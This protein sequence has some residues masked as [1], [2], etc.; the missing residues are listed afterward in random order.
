TVAGES[1]IG[2]VCRGPIACEH[3][4][5]CPS[6]RICVAGICQI[7][8]P[9]ECNPACLPEE[10]CAN[11]SCQIP[12]PADC[13]QTP[14]LLPGTVCLNGMCRI[15]NDADDDRDMDCDGL[16]DWNERLRG[17]NPLNSDTDGDGLLD[18]VE[19]GYGSL[20]D[21]LC[22][23]RYA[24]LPPSP[25]NKT[26]PLRIDTDCDGLTDGEEDANGNGVF[27]LGETNPNDPDTDNDGILD[28][29]ELGRQFSPDS[30]CAGS[31]PQLPE[32]PN[33][34]TDPL[35][36]DSD[37]DGMLDGVEDTNQNGRV[38]PGETNPNVFDIVDPVVE[39]ACS[40]TNLVPVDIRRNLAAQ[41]ALGLPMGFA[42]NY[43]DIQRGN[44]SGLMGVDLPRNV[45]FVAWRHVSWQNIGAVS[46]LNMLRNLARAQA[47]SLVGADSATI[48]TFDSWD[49][50]PPPPEHNALSVSFEIS[51]NMSP[52]ARVNDIA[53]R[54][55]GGGTGS[56]T[57]GANVGNRQYV[58]AQ[59]VLR[60]DGEVVVVMAVALDN[61][62]V[63]GT[64]A[65][66]GLNDVAGGAA[67]ARYF[68]RTVVQC[69][70]G[71]VVRREVDILFVVDDSS[72]MSDLQGRLGMAGNTMA[73]ALNNSNLD[74]RV[75]LVS[76]DYHTTVSAATDG[77]NNN[78]RVIRGF[79]RDVG[80]FQAWLTQNNYC[81]RSDSTSIACSDSNLVT[82]GCSCVLSRDVACLP[83]ATGVGHSGGCWLG[84]SGSA[85]EGMLG[86]ARLALI[87]M[88]APNADPRIQLRANSEVIV[89][90][91]SDT[92]DQTRTL[93]H[94]SGASSYWENIQNFVRFFRGEDTTVNTTTTGNGAPIVVSPVRPNITIQVNAIYCPAGAN[95]GGGN[96]VAAGTT[97]RIQRVVEETGGYLASI[98]S[99]AAI[100]NTMRDIV[101]GAI[102]RGG[103]VTQKPFLGA[104]L[105]VA[106]Q[107]PER[108]V[109]AGGACNGSNVQRSR[110]HGFDYDGI[111]QAVTFFGDCRPENHT[112]VA[113]SYRAWESTDRT[114]LPCQYDIHFDAN[115][116]D[117]CRGLRSCELS[118]DV[119]VCPADCG[120]CGQ[121]SHCVSDRRRCECVPN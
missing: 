69:E 42:N 74:W 44:T 67:L 101:E 93:Y 118:T 105:R 84:N 8:T 16:E 72:S 52:A 53:T 4:N 75:A 94:S 99:E 96:I 115:A 41:L 19:V 109:S 66:F 3:D 33:N 63:A 81:R 39:A 80:E 22:A 83:D 62:N 15:P 11:G 60:A 65:F 12:G 71:E 64:P 90:I 34:P 21:P 102:G 32:P 25:T 87:N 27:D 6:G 68:D 113:I 106:I 110:E 40:A 107:T 108:P 55:L 37:G 111:A 56:L 114:Q 57:S 86:A 43:V 18:G 31:F 100:A 20:Q 7:E 13:S 61:N 14:C 77:N 35:N 28:G 46:D 29:I 112:E 17:T 51:G 95:C 103:L 76:S 104:S 82:H 58:N 59:Y 49:A 47:Q 9:G 91:L 5:D 38:D 98:Q 120:G 54:L 89:V 70:R 23:N 79:T 26:N 97:T 116:V 119:C 121:G 45:A 50:P 92:E 48:G 73:A 36:P 85:Y 24:Q 78:R 30:S 88:N 117:Y 1:C 2:G 10:S